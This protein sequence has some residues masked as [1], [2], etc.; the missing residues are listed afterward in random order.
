MPVRSP[1]RFAFDR[2]RSYV[3]IG[4]RSNLHPITTETRGLSG[5]IEV[6][7]SPEGTLDLDVEVRG[8]LELSTDRL[9]SGNRL[10]DREL[11]RRIDS[12][13]YPTI[14]GQIVR[15][16]PSG[17]AYLVRG[18]LSFHGHTRTFEH[19]MQIRVREDL[20]IEM[21]GEYVF[22]IRQFDMKPPSMLMLKVYPE[23]SVRVE[24]H[25]TRQA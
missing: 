21:T 4:A 22:D 25:G 19:E 3:K 14:E 6:A 7:V 15:V 24:L 11:H 2:E 10:Y 8:R 17:G 12:R 23:V 5:W 13:R 18:D 16:A 1:A 20:A 9:S